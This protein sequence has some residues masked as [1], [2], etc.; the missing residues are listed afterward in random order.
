MKGIF[1]TILIIIFVA[2]AIFGVLVFSG[3]IDLSGEDA[4]SGGTVVLWG[5]VN[6]GVMSE[7]IENFNQTNEGFSVVYVEKSPENF[8]DNLLEALASGV[9]PDLFLL[10][11]NLVFYYS[12][13]IFTIPY[14][15]YPLST[16]KQTFTGAGDVFLSENGM[17]GFPLTVDPLM[18]YYNRSTLDSNA[19]AFPPKT[20]DELSTMVPVITKKDNANKILKSG[21]ALGYFS[22]VVHA[23][24]ILIAM[25]M[26]TGNPIVAREDQIPRSS[27]DSFRGKKDLGSVLQFYADFADPSQNIY[28]W[29]R[30][31]SNSV[32]AF[33]KEDL[34]FYFGFSSELRTLVNRNPNQNLGVAPFP[35]LD[36]NSKFTSSKVTGVAIS[37]ASKNLNTA[38]VVASKMAT[39]DFAQ[40]LSLALQIPPVRRDLLA[41]KPADTYGPLFYDSALFAKSWLDPSSP[42]T[43]NIFRLMVDGVISNNTTSRQ[44]ITDASAKLDL[45]LI[46]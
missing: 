37:S 7:L 20:W 34:A 23:K 14:T 44:A 9:G 17:L 31:F 5:T 40:K 12:N 2:G 3:A 10:P 27:L 28:S 32:D 19:I 38:F 30:S 41:I 43:N 1:Q 15:S 39:G 36:L 35:Q 4:Q 45:L 16:F 21:V 6:A 33:T 11:D 42:G 46:K 22:N 29:N 18:M 24:D 13:K 25:F 26:Q 8:N